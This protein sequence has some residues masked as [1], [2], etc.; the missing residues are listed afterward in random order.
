[1]K[2]LIVVL[3]VVLANAEANAKAIDVAGVEFQP[4]VQVGGQLLQLNGAGLRT[5]AFFN[6][7]AAGLYVRE[8]AHS[9]A[10]LLAQ[11]GP[12]LVVIAM[13]RDVD[14]KSLSEAVS[15]GLQANHT[16]SQLAAFATQIALLEANLKAVGEARQGDAIR[17][18][19]T[20]EAGTRIL[21]NGQALGA[22]IPGG[23]FFTAI[24]RNWIGDV[25]VD[26]G[27]KQALVG[28]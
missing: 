18:E 7:Y 20:P 22:V 9:A 15:G 14:G 21:V 19:F 3:A 26:E 23:E 4:S 25:P 8:K 6:V 5:R 16:E 24:L 12:R 1:M 28:R 2:R 27:L 13:L 11:Q 17:F 10:A